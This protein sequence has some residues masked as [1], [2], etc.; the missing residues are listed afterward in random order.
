MDFYPLR[1]LYITIDNFGKQDV[2]L[3]KQKYVAEP[4]DEAVKIVCIKVK[5]F[6]YPSGTHV[7]DSD[8]LANAV[9]Y[10]RTPN[11]LE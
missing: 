9:H 10:N 6:S 2:H 1:T 3:P 8:S 5:G 11:H 7:E 4:G